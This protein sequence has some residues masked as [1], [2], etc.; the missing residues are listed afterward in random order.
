MKK[1]IDTTGR[2]IDEATNSALG[3]LGLDR[4]QV[5]VEVLAAPKVGF[6]G[7]GGAAAKVRVYYGEDRSARAAAFLEGLFT[8]MG[9]DVTLKHG[10]NDAGGIE[11]DISGSGAAL[12][13]GR[14][15]ETLDAL[16]HITSAVANRGEEDFTRVTLDTEGYRAKRESAVIDLARRSAEKA[17][18]YHRNMTL[19]PMNAYSRRIVHTALQDYPGV[20]THSVGAEPNRRVVI[21]VQGGDKPRYKQ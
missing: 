13:I 15:G 11:F 19:E 6:L 9:V 20:S 5:S 12:L 21:A 3:Q 17:L 4:D 1:Y 8:R 10:V 2:T 14:R 18:K 16:Q 7:I